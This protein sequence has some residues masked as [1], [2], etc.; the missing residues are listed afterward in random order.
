MRNPILGYLRNAN[1]M[2]CIKVRGH[3]MVVAGLVCSRQKIR[4]IHH[5]RGPPPPQNK[6]IGNA[7]A[8]R[9]PLEETHPSW[10]ALD[11]NLHPLDQLSS[12]ILT[13]NTTVLMVR[14]DNKH[15]ARKFELLVGALLQSFEK[16]RIEGRILREDTPVGS[17]PLSCASILTNRHFEYDI[18]MDEWSCLHSVF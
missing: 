6:H 18:S 12:F 13:R 7:Y 5:F 10:R 14:W 2:G 9:T 16:G 11:P 3:R 1:V 17:D 15:G 4:I 8:A